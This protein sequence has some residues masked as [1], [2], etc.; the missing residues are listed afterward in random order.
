MIEGLDSSR[1]AQLFSDVEG[2]QTAALSYLVGH[3][4]RLDMT[5]VAEGVNAQLPNEEA[6]PP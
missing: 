2:A 4:T 1:L 3:M 5:A 6:L